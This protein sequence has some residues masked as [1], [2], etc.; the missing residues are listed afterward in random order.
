[1]FGFDFRQ[2]AGAPAIAPAIAVEWSLYRAVR[3][4]VFIASQALPQSVQ[5]LLRT[6]R[7]ETDRASVFR[8]SA[9]S[10]PY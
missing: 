10:F 1:M 6:T 5:M 4:S 3:G 2:G 9:S 8:L 7:P